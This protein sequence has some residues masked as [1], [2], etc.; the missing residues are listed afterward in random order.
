MLRLRGV[1]IVPASGLREERR[2]VSF[3]FPE[4]ALA[5]IDRAAGRLHEDRTTF[6]LQAIV[7]KAQAVLRDQAVFGLD[8]AAFAAFVDRLDHP[9]AAALPLQALAGKD[10]LWKK[11]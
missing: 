9:P 3:R 10:P 6:V 5:L 1:T 2:S 11:A 7:E 8:D 4:S